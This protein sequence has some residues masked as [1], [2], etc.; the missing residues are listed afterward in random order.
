MKSINLIKIAAVVL[1]GITLNIKVQADT[2]KYYRT[3]RPA[4]GQMMNCIN[5]TGD[6]CDMEMMYPQ[7]V[8]E[9]MLE[10]DYLSEESTCDVEPWMLNTDYLDEAGQPVDGW[11]FCED[12]LAETESGGS[13]EQWMFDANYLPR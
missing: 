9:W 2:D 12:R 10:S 3:V 13:L 4:I 8:E 11:M 7:P 5:L 6:I 1:L